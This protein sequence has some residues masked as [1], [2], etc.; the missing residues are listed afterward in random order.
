M[1]NKIL[2]ERLNNE[3]DEL[4][5]PGLMTERVQ[6]CS[7]L[8][9]LPKFKMEALLNGV[10]AIDANSIQKIADELEVNKDWLLGDIKKKTKH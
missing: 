1:T 9:N 3:L 8:F 2:T 4:G 7:K 5:V 10:I 6:V